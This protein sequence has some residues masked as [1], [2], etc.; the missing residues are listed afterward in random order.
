MKYYDPE[1]R[2]AEKV[3]SRLE[4]ARRLESGEISPLEL[5]R[6]NSF[7]PPHMLEGARIVRRGARKVSVPPDTEQT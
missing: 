1:K 2:A 4:D 3:A 6:E 7:I 5:S